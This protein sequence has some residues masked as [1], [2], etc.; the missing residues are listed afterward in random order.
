[1]SLR[2]FVLSGMEAC[3]IGIPRRTCALIMYCE[4]ERLFGFR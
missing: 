3:I 1:M 4:N 2:F